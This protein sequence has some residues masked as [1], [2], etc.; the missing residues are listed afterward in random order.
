M[1]IWCALW[2]FRVYTV[3]SQKTRNR[4]QGVGR[5]S[6]LISHSVKKHPFHTRS[7]VKLNI[8]LGDITSLLILR[9]LWSRQNSNR[10]NETRRM[11]MVTLD[12]F[13]HVLFI[14]LMKI[15]D[16]SQRN[17]NILALS[18]YTVVISIC[19]TGCMLASLT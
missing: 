7:H 5:K 2:W 19:R 14:S 16:I 3:E 15:S 11:I 4:H 17:E 6:R 18:P 10:C 8:F 9:V 13:E 12:L 1:I